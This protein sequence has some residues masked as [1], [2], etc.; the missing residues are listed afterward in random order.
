MTRN[1]TAPIVAH[2]VKGLSALAGYPKIM[3][4]TVFGSDNATETLYLDIRNMPQLVA[5][6]VDQ[7]GNDACDSRYET[8]TGHR[9][10]YGICKIW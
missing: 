5:R 2:R 9:S 6:L 7:D 8:H 10:E 1:A 4:M 3:K